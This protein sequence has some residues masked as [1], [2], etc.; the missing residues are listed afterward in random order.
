MVIFKCLLLE[1]AAFILY[2][3]YFTETNQGLAT[4]LYPLSK[5]F[6]AFNFSIFYIDISNYQISIYPTK[7]LLRHRSRDRLSNNQ[8]AGLYFQS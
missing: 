1:L 2:S 3:P 4:F 8:S 7:S 5:L 6:S